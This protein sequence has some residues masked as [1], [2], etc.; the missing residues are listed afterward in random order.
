MTM[1]TKKSS[2][3]L[4]KTQIK[5]KIVEDRTSPDSIP[6]RHDQGYQTRESM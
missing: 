1:F 5:I 2:Y 4:N 3:I 6:T